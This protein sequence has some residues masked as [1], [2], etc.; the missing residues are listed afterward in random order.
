MCQLPT[1]THSLNAS[2]NIY[3]CIWLRYSEVLYLKLI[4]IHKYLFHWNNNPRYFNRNGSKMNRITGICFVWEFF[5]QKTTIWILILQQ[6]RRFPQHNP[7]ITLPKCCSQFPSTLIRANMKYLL[8][9]SIQRVAKTGPLFGR[10]DTSK[11]KLLTVIL[12]PKL[13]IY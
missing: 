6:Y 5:Q 8:N 1:K 4:S 3:L 13:I 2:R 9:S 12:I 11:M 7:Q 10:K